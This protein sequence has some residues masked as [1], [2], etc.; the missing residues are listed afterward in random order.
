MPP[1]PG[2]GGRGPFEGRLAVLLAALAVGLLV[3]G[4][5]VYVASGGDRQRTGKPVAE[6]AAT[7]SGSPSVDRGD[8]RGAGGDTPAYDHNAGIGAGESPVWLRENRTDLARKGAEQYGPWRV[9]GVVVK[10]MYK[11]VVAYAV[12]DGR[13]MWKAALETRLCSVPHAPSVS[14]KLVVGVLESDTAEGDCTG[15]QQ[16]DLATGRA[17]WRIRVPREYTDDT[18]RFQMAV[19]GETV[20]ITRRLGM[21]GFSVTDGRR[22]FGTSTTGACFPVSLAGGAKLIYLVEC[23]GP[24]G[25]TGLSATR[26]QEL[27]PATGRAKWTHQYADGWRVGQVYSVDPLVVSVRRAKVWNI[28]AFTPDG[29]IRS[30]IAPEFPVSDHCDALASYDVQ[31]CYGAV[32]DAE[33]L[34]IAGGKTDGAGHVTYA[35]VA[36]DLD[37]GTEKWRAAG[38]DGRTMWPLAVE[39]GKLV[40]YLATRPGTAGAVAV[41]AP[42]GGAPQTVLRSPA[43][44]VG[45]ERGFEPSR[46]RLA[47]AGGRI[48]LL[49]DRVFSP[50]P[51]AVDHSI[52][53]FGK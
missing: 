37:T 23:L 29:G 17:G 7:P 14:G 44:A 45:A 18:G 42:T 10:A 9:G 25:G 28:T 19:V 43:A 39:N 35:V 3:I 31:G 36:V 51:R 30:Q 15:L 53:S 8:G 4:G 26:V 11:E 6:T 38:P 34:Y 47:W 32:T 41:L 50:R 40:V 33:T 1:P 21:I 2:G 20:A 49:K 52:L 13:E 12:A 46:A 27:D 22:L 48:F 5:G 16:I 24:K